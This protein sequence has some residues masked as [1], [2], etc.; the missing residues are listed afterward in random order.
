MLSQQ[1]VRRGL[2]DPRVLQAMAEVPREH[3]LP[4]ELAEFAYADAP[5]P[6]FEKQTISQ[7]YIVALM[8]AL[9]QLVP[10]DRVLEVGTGSGYA[11]AV[12]ARLA[13]E[14]HTVERHARLAEWASERLHELGVANV[15]V[16]QG[17]GTLGWAAAAPYDAILVAAAGPAVPA[18][19]R[20]QLR[21]GGRLIMPVGTRA[22]QRL[23]RVRRRSEDKFETETF[24]GV[25]FVP[26]IGGQGWPVTC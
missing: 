20:A 14:V 7:P 22:D 23:Q 10:T 13:G 11:A 18:A 15:E 9:A 3:F 6:I 2:T 19:L 1:L 21:V 12:M 5:L 8:V 4:P 17:D 16:H 25:R 26:L 24:G